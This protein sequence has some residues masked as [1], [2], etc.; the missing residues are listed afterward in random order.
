MI[1][2]LKATRDSQRFWCWLR[3]VHFDSA[4]W[5][6][7]RSLTPGWDAHRGGWS[8]LRILVQL[9]PPCAAHREVF[10]GNFGLLDSAVWSTPRSLTP[11]SDAHRGVWIRGVIHT[12]ESDSTMGCIPWVFWK[13]FINWLSGGMHTAEL[14][15]VVCISLRSLELFEYFGAVDSGMCGTPR[16]F[17]SKFGMLD[18]A[19]GC[20]PRSLTPWYDASNIRISRRNRNRIQKY[21][22]C[23][24]G[25][26]MGS[27]YEKN[28]RSKISWHTP[29]KE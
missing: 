5:C 13:I 10:F 14:D 20:T 23:L 8:Y 3:G 11:R 9:T 4:M 1:V 26:Q 17:F 22:A 27:N 6:T 25:A 16:S 12:G 29:F 24:S 18:S 15:S 21:F 7:P 2:P 19:E 28:W